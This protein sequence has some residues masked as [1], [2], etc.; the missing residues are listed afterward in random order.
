MIGLIHRWRKYESQIIDDLLAFL[1]Y[2][3]IFQ[4]E[5]T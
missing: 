1:E 4:R 2:E 5:I 3:E